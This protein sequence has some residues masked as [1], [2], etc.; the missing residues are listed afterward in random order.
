MHFAFLHYYIL[1]SMLKSKMQAPPRTFSP[2]KNRGQ[3][4]SM[5]IV[6]S[7]TV[8][9][10]FKLQGCWNWQTSRPQT[11]VFLTCGFKSRPLHHLKPKLNREGQFRLFFYPN[12]RLCISM[13]NACTFVYHHA[14]ACIFL[15]LDDSNALCW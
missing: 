8:T 15:R 12:R 10:Y 1:R 7:F 3:K 5:R 13:Y 6:N 2:C 14:S 9:S 4:T 11:P